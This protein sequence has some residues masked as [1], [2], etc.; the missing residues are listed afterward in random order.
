MTESR[1]L[2][3]AWIT[4][5]FLAVVYVFYARFETPSPGI[6]IG[7]TLGIAGTLLMLATETLYSIRK[8]TQLLQFG[9]LRTWLSVHIYMGIVGPTMVLMHTAWKFHGLA[10]ITLLLTAV[11]ALSGFFGR[12]IYTSIPRTMSGKAVEHR[13]LTG[14]LE[15]LNNQLQGWLAQKPAQLQELVRL[16]TGQRAEPVPAGA[17]TGNAKA[18][19]SRV[20]DDWNYRRA[21]RQSLGQLST[22]ERAQI[23]EIS[24]LLQ[25]R[26]R[27]ER[28]AASWSTARTLMSRWRAAHVPIG[29]ALFTSVALHVVAALVFSTF[30]R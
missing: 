14:Q 15:Q 2:K 12:Y 5:F 29:T 8:R 7:H 20:W 13:Q 3:A 9:R 16:D 27:L 30:S 26:H 28:Q 18:V 4:V 22:V 24:Q 11:V 6:P 21:L 19:L 25:K 17:V 10:G 23:Q 1:E